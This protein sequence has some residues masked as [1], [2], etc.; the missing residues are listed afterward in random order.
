VFGLQNGVVEYQL[1]QTLQDVLLALRALKIDVLS[2]VVEPEPRNRNFLT[3]G[4]GTGTVINYGS[5]T[6]TRYEIM[7][8]INFI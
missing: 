8:L 5:G 2:S 6:G 7:Y 3:S 1:A 4:T